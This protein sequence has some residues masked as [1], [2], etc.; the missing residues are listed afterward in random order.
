MKIFKTSLFIEA[1][2]LIL[3]NIP[4]FTQNIKLL[5]KDPKIN[6]AYTITSIMKMEVDAKIK[7]R[8]MAEGEL[9]TKLSN[10]K[11]FQADEIILNAENKNIKRIQI[12]Y[13]KAEEI[14]KDQ[15][16]EQVKTETVTGKDYIIDVNG[17]SSSILYP[18]NEKPDNS[19]INYIDVK[20]LIDPLGLNEHFAGIEFSKGISVP[21]I[22][23]KIIS[24][25][26]GGQDLKLNSNEVIFKETRMINNLNFGAF[27]VDI[28]ML[29]KVEPNSFRQMKLKGELLVSSDNINIFFLDLNGSVTMQSQTEDMQLSGQ[30]TVTLNISREYKKK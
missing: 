29:Y 11:D 30:G 22:D 28:D 17:N 23:L 5:I 9:N 18:N 7:I 3:I 26:I 4:V 25:L 16:K 21:A 15:D 14:N 13:S 24:K 1:Y 12:S 10:D 2:I 27:E 20:S 6:D 19:E 8:N